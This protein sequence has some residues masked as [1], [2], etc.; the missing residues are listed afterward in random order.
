M[1]GIG[2]NGVWLGIRHGAPRAGRGECGARAEGR[3]LVIDGVA[4][5]ALASRAGRHSSCAVNNTVSKNVL[6]VPL[7]WYKYEFYF[8]IT[9]LLCYCF[10][11]AIINKQKP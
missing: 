7:C 10:F 9:C 3:R 4:S 1:C 5:A 6:R 8:N 11:F 2:H